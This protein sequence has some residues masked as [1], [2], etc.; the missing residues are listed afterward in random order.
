MKISATSVVNFKDTPLGPLPEDWQVVRLGELVAEGILWIK[1][2]FPQGEHNQTGLGVPH[3][4]PFNI[5]DT[6]D[7]TLCQIKYV[8][9]PSEDSPYW[10]LQGDIIFNNTNSEELVGKT[11]FFNLDGKFVISNHMTLIRVSSDEINSYW[12][13]KF[14]HWLWSQGVFLGLCRR[15]V[16]QA[17][18]SLERLKQVAIPLP[19]LAEQRAI[20]HVLRTVQEAKQATE[21][22]VAA[23]RELKRSL[24]RHL[25][26][27]GPLPLG[28]KDFS[29]QRETEIGPIPAHWQVVRLGEVATVRAGV[30]FPVKYQGCKN[31]QF[32]FYKVS[33]MNLPGNDIEMEQSANWLD[34]STARLIKAKPFP[35][36]TIIFPKVGGALY[37]NK[38]RLLR[39]HA[40]LD[41]NLIG[42]MV[43]SIM[44]CYPNFLFRWIEMIDLRDLSNPGPLPSINAT[45]VKDMKIPLPPLPEQR[46]IARILQAV[47]RRIQAEEAYARALGDLF[48]SLLHELMSG[49]R[50]VEFTTENT[51]GT[52]SAKA[53]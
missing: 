35:P 51:E 16:N 46:E 38:K 47:D 52:L 32:P 53:I 26:T 21:R 18:V 12:L 31:G 42:V 50:R 3:L 9:S 30:A 4:R 5:T 43:V 27:Y 41:N 28:A 44:R 10:V 6:G 14:L 20:A 13:S 15:H 2:G 40:F 37:T 19:P 22:V 29:P 33:D 24:M 8:S 25:F 49:R 48:Q 45:R 11:A 1:N 7:I 36:G 34:D 39:V 17:S 23:L